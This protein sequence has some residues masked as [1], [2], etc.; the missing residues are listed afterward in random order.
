MF[1][2][3]Q[4]TEIPES[5]TT[6]RYFGIR[7]DKAYS[8]YKK[9]KVRVPQGGVLG[10]VLNLVYTSDLFELENNRLET[11]ADNTALMLQ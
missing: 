7:E 1:L 11:F 10:P 4:Y 5:N 6:N 8:K 3:K 9:I 2:S